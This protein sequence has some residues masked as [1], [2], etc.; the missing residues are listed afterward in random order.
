VPS[1]YVLLC[2][3]PAGITSHGRGG[4]GPAHA[5]RKTRVGHAGTLD[6]FATG[7]LLAWWGERP[8][9]SAS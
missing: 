1:D 5:A 7:L 8:E 4:L 9:P 3:K 2:D 6:P